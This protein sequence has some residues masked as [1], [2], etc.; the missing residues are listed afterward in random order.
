MWRMAIPCMCFCISQTKLVSSQRNAC[1]LRY[2]HN[3]LFCIY[4]CPAN[5]DPSTFRCSKGIVSSNVFVARCVSLPSAFWC[6]F[7]I[8][9]ISKGGAYNVSRWVV[10]CCETRYGFA[11]AITYFHLQ[12]KIIGMF[13]VRN[14]SLCSLVGRVWVILRFA[15]DGMSTCFHPY[16]DRRGPQLCKSHILITGH[17]LTPPPTFPMGSSQLG[18][19]VHRGFR[20]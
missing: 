17:Y 6:L 2:V 1:F 3:R 20:Y 14:F 19:P 9:C 4:V 8:F 16:L 11:L 12:R 13:N 15:S 5:R 10:V 18:K 7:F